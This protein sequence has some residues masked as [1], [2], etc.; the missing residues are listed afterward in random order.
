[1][2]ILI[3]ETQYKF[4]NERHYKVFDEEQILHNGYPLFYHGAT[5]KKL[6]GKNGIHIG[7][8]MAATQALQAKIGVPAHGEWDGTRQYG[9]TLLAGKKTLE[10]MNYVMG[11]DPII[12]FNATEDVPE[13]DYFPH[14]RKKKAHYFS[15]DKLIPLDSKPI[16]FQVMITGEMSNSYDNPI[17]DKKANNIMYRNIKLGKANKGFYYTNIW[18][19]EN[20]ISAVVPNGSFLKIIHQ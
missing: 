16:V 8:K 15:S 5:D 4:I 18:E 2:K 11:Y 10:K 3:S 12:N 6:N 13:N 9:K 1:M 7:T 20:S 14:Q 19:D 17:T